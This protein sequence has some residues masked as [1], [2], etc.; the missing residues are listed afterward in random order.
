VSH[1]LR[2]RTAIAAIRQRLF[3]AGLTCADIDRS[4][5]LYT[6]QASDALFEPNQPGENAIANALGTTPQ[7]LWPHRF[8]SKGN[9]LSPQPVSNYRIRNQPRQRKNVDSERQIERA[10]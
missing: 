3:V 2:H 7:K 1:N 9:R 8:D 10:A 6:N 5:G 4:Y